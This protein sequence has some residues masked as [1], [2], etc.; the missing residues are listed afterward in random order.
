[1]QALGDPAGA[2]AAVVAKAEVG[3]VEGAAVGATA[4]GGC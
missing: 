4:L 3:A 1:M 2:L